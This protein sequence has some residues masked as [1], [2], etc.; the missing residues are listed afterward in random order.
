MNLVINYKNLLFWEVFSIHKDTK[1]AFTN[2]QC[3]YLPQSLYVRIL[4]GI[5]VFRFLFVYNMSMGCG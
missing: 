3:G 4:F 5:F 1:A 2:L